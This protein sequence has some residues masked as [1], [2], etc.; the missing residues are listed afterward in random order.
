MV[1]NTKDLAKQTSLESD[2]NGR[3]VVQVSKAVNIFPPGHPPRLCRS[4]SVRNPMRKYP[5]KI[6]PKS[7]MALSEL[8]ELLLKGEAYCLPLTLK[9]GSLQPAAKPQCR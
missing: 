6:D 1:G 4:V 7:S 8:R 2:K 9:A 5:R 3:A